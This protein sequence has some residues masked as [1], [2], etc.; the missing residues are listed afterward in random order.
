MGKVIRW[1]EEERVKEAVI[2]K[3][4]KICYMHIQIYQNEPHYS[5]LLITLIKT[6]YDTKKYILS[7]FT[8]NYIN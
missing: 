5:R 4:S 1:R 6:H 3:I 8:I 7:Y 2:L